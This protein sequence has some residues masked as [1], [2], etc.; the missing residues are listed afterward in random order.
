MLVRARGGKKGEEKGRQTFAILV[1]VIEMSLLLVKSI[2][3]VLPVV[4]YW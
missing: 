3:Y 2:T 1:R 4:R